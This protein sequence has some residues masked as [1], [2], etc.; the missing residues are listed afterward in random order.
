MHFGISEGNGGLK[1]GSR[2]SLCTD[3]FWN[4]PLALKGKKFKIL[5]AVSDEDLRRQFAF[6]HDIDP[7]LQLGIGQKS[8][9]LKKDELQAWF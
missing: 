2:P 5:E 8:E 4:C 9:L 1:Y 7:T 3:I 6:V